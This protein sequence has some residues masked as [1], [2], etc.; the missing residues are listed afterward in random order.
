M[1][2]TAASGAAA[3]TNA[4]RSPTPKGGA[5][6]RAL[7]DSTIE[8]LASTGYA[9]TTTQAVL[10]H[11]GLSRGSL[12]HQFRTR[13]ILMVEAAEEAVEQMFDAVRDKLSAV[14]DPID[15]LR[16]YP[17]ALWEVQNAP[18]ARA[19]AELQL[20]SRW[21]T[22]LQTRLRKSVQAV[23]ERLGREIREAAEDIGLGDPRKLMVE[24]GALISAMQG[25]AVSSTLVEDQQPVEAVLRALTR[26]Y[27]DCLDELL[28]ER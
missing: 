3:I 25:L 15:A 14:S 21:E 7:L 9:A 16:K 8:L 23:N 27:N 5:T 19:Y 13:E 18:A 12:L 20:A 6:R 22:G 4:D 10:N 2:Q 1:G 24:I 26:H 11:C 17:R 28:A